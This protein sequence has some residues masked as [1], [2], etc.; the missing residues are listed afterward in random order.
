MEEKGNG[1]FRFLN[2]VLILF[3]IDILILMLIAALWGEG[4]NS[5]STIFQFG[6]K[7]LSSVTMLQFL[8][9]SVTI[10]LLRY[11]FYSEKIF[12][13]LRTIYRIT[14]MLIGI[15]IS[16]IIYIL[17]CGWFAMD[18]IYAWIGFLIC[19]V[20]GFTLGLLIMVLKTKLDNRQYDKLLSHYKEMREEDEN[21]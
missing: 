19:F 11:F 16:L 2:E 17:L 1:I 9:S 6:R 8:L 21:E 12:K 15:L 3:S 4:A 18:D 10:V 14:F 7:G 5:L 13:S 20:G